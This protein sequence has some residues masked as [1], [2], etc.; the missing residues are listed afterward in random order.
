MHVFA[1]GSL[2]WRPGFAPKDS[3]PA[4]ARGWSRKWCVASKIHRGT[5]DKPGVVLG[6][7]EGG[8]CSGLLYAVNSC[9]RAP[10]ARYLELREM[11]EIGYRPAEIEV[12]TSAGH[13]RA[14]TYVSDPRYRGHHNP[15]ETL[16][17]ILSAKGAS[18]TNIDYASKTFDAL[19][20]LGVGMAEE[21]T[22]IPAR[23][24]STI[25]ASRAIRLGS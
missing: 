16:P 13:V 7:V 24:V 18:G 10:V 25:L 12:E 3:I 8:E 5:S 15:A 1:Y 21:E 14:L 6:L 17:R 4:L 20:Q 11:A 9:D 23:L 22:G 19:L 2:L